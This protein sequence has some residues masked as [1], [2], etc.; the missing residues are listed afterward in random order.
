VISNKE[1]GRNM[2]RK[3]IFLSFFLILIICQIQAV[4]DRFYLGLSINDSLNHF[5][6]KA[7]NVTTKLSSD[8][9]KNHNKAL[10]SAFLGYGY[11]FH[12]FYLG[13]ELNTYF[14]KRS[15]IISRPGVTLL[16][17]SFLDRVSVQDYFNGD[18]LIGGKPI[19]CMLVYLRG[20]VGCANIK[21]HQF[22]NEA[23]NTPSFNADKNKVAVRGGVGINYTISCHFDLGADYIF[24]HYKKFH[25]FWPQFN[26]NFTEKTF[27]HYFGLLAIYR[28]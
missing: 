15:S 8:E 22:E 9:K 23:A 25:A 27:A 20:G 6:L 7:Q 4:K 3:K 16:P 18:I 21:L 11:T 12:R 2:S 28:F 1:R 5:N 24:T 10:G 14:P 26:I 17:F 19:N 13:G